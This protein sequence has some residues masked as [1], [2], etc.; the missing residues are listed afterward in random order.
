MFA[1][2]DQPTGN[3]RCILARSETIAAPVVVEVSNVTLDCRRREILPAA[4]GI[5]GATAQANVPS[6]PEVGIALIDVH[7]VVIKDCVL[8]SVQRRIDFGVAIIESD[9]NQV[10]TNTMHV[11]AAGVTLG[12]ADE[13]SVDQNVIDWD[14]SGDGVRCGRRS[15][16][17]QVTGNTLVSDGAPAKF[18]RHWPGT[19]T[20]G[21]A[22]DTGIFNLDPPSTVASVVINVVIGGRLIQLTN[23]GLPR[24]EDNR[25]IGNRVSLPGPHAGKNHGGIVTGVMSSRAVIVDNVVS[26]GRPG[27]RSA[28]NGAAQLFPFP[29]TCSGDPARYCA[30]SADCFI[31][32]IDPV[33]KGTCGSFPPPQITDA[34]VLGSTVERNTLH[35]PF[36]TVPELALPCDSSATCANVDPT[37]NVCLASGR[38]GCNSNG[39]C[40]AG[41]LCLPN[42]V[43]ASNIDGA[44]QLGG[45]TIDARAA[46]NVITADGTPFGFSING[47]SLNATTNC[48]APAGPCGPATVTRNVIDG[49][50][51][52]LGLFAQGTKSFGAQI[53][54]NDVTASLTKGVGG[55]PNGA[56]AYAVPSELSV[57]GAGNFWGHDTAPGFSSVDTDNPN[58]RDSN[59]FCQPVAA[60]SSPPPPTCP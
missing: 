21:G 16:R 48:S 5:D 33:S 58:I 47:D 52:G 9:R 36:G 31:A 40:A 57:G 26:G 32:G 28:G 25:Y 45:S 7:G 20:E 60:L 34:R 27:I 4:A 12:A 14:G 22:L 30:T 56:M 38:C 24:V 35:G 39:D 50:R 29:G 46:S 19:D 54:L 10:Q 11:R 49:A 41:S 43:C 17:N 2:L 59:P 1:G 15:D 3:T 6:T 13:N 23:L 44:I 51:Y 53:F 42:Q 37:G 18:V 55:I 8:G